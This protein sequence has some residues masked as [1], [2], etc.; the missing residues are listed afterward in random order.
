[1]M[2]IEKFVTAESID[3]IYYDASYYLAPD[4]KAGDD[5]YAVLREAIEKTGRVALSRV[6][7]G[8]RERTIALRPMA[9]GLV[10]HTLNE[11]RDLNEAQP[12]FEHI[13]HAKS[14]PEMVQL[15]V[16][17]IDR[18]TSEYDPADL[19]DR[20]E[21]RL[22]AMLDA[23]IQGEQIQ[24]EAPAAP[25]SNVID[26]M[27]ALRKSLGEP[28]KVVER[29][30]PAAKAPAKKAQKAAEEQRKQPGLKLP[31]EGG[32]TSAPATPGKSAEPAARQRR[33][34]S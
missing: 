14:D 10:A 24:E 34:A 13:A 25:T 28:P 30:P 18:Q 23:K 26:L 16:Q 5:V 3:P 32:K 17:L 4:G 8:Q 12:L 6:V 2:T 1:M 7:I 21:T 20:Y 22:R 15:A 33:R 27:A 11:Q 9:G 19:E 31:I 29:V